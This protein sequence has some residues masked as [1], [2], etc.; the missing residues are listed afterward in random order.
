MNEMKNT[1]DEPPPA[2]SE[3][4]TDPPL[5][6]PSCTPMP[7]DRESYSQVPLP[8]TTPRPET[9]HRTHRGRRVRKR[10]AKGVKLGAAAIVTTVAVPV[11]LVGHVAYEGG[12]VALQIIVAPA[13]ICVVC[14]C[15][16][17]FDY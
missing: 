14:F 16:D 8:T 5:G 3:C 7:A 17:D 12:K 2:Y 9:Q 13:L 4:S 6:I 1:Q 10:L 11:I 15:L